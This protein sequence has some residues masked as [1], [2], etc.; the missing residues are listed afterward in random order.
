MDGVM[1]GD[2]SFSSYET[3]L[4]RFAI[5]LTSGGIDRNQNLEYTWFFWKNSMF[6]IVLIYETLTELSNNNKGF[7]DWN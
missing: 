7:D 3:G 1:L 2:S 5:A 6:M 4:K